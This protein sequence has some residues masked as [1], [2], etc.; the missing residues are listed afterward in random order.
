MNKY[1]FFLP[2]LVMLSIS[3]FTFASENNIELK[4]ACIKDYPLVGDETDPELLNIYRQICDRK[5]KKNIELKSAL[6]I[7][8]AQRFQAI[9]KNLKALQWVEELRKQNVQHRDLTDVAFLA[10]VGI[11]ESNLQYMRNNEMRYLNAEN[12]YPAAKKLSDHIQIS[13]PEPDT[14]NAKAVT[15]STVRLKQRVKSSTLSN[16]T[17]GKANSLSRPQSVNL[18]SRAIKTSARNTT[19]ATKPQSNNSIT[20]G[21]SPFASFNKN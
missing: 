7:Q 18:Q 5:N 14:S 13:L 15:A 8:A 2:L 1:K 12:T 9:G 4:K 20:S 17:V 19:A 10:G 21:S 11:S 6:S 16:R 3:P